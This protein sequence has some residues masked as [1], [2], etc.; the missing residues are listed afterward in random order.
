MDLNE[1]LEEYSNVKPL[2]ECFNNAKRN[3]RIYK[4][5]PF[6]ESP[7]TYCYTFIYFCQ[8]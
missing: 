7:R 6:Y 8:T 5:S 4:K 1:W 2:A 3:K